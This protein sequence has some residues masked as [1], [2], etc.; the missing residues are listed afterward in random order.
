MTIAHGFSS[1]ACVE[2]TRLH[3]ERAAKKNRRRKKNIL[4]GSSLNGIGSFGFDKWVAIGKGYL[5]T[6]AD[7]KSGLS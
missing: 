3:L 4:R 6:L 1:S 7:W 2:H 5:Q